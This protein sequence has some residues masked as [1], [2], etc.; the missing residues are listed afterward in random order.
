[1][2]RNYYDQ[3]EWGEP[4]RQDPAAPPTPGADRPGGRHGG[5]LRTGAGA[6]RAFFSVWPSF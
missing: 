4:A 3:S 1:M 6:Y 2:R 5:A